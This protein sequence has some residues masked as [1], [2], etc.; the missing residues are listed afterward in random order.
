MENATQALH[1]I[2]SYVLGRDVTPFDDPLAL[3][4]GPFDDL[5]RRPWDYKRHFWPPTAGV[6]TP[7]DQQAEHGTGQPSTGTAM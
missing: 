2:T 6:E 1:R 5:D 7:D 4:E 3:R